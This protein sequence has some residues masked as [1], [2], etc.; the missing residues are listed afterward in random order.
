M[1]RTREWKFVCRHAYGP[2]QLFNLVADP[3]ERH[4]L[5]EDP[6]QEERIQE[7]KH[8]MDVWFARYVVPEIDGLRQP[9]TTHGQRD[10]ASRS[11]LAH[12]PPP[13]GF[14]V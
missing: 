13:P 12:W 3:D 4:N 2:H 9:G 10:R 5:A 14:K 7:M 11:A 6:R 1:I 8:A